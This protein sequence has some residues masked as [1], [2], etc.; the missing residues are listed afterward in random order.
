MTGIVH[1]STY[2]YRGK[3]IIYLFLVPSE[4]THK[5][6]TPKTTTIQSTDNHIQPQRRVI[7]DTIHNKSI[8]LKWKQT[9]QIQSKNHNN[10][11]KKR[12]WKKNASKPKPAFLFYFQFWLWMHRAVCCAN[13]FK[14]LSVDFEWFK[15]MAYKK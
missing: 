5:M 15:R 4:Q 6:P 10:N 8:R 13:A 11:K 7:N 9:K 1:V 14:M 12:I 3:K 2:T